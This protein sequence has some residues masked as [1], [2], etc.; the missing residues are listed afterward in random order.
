MPSSFLSNS[1]ILLFLFTNPSP[2]KDKSEKNFAMAFVRLMKEDGTV[3]QDGLQ[4]LVI[5]KVRKN[6]TV[7]SW[8]SAVSYSKKGKWNIK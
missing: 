6:K 8:T 2:A 7:N 3:L 4:D 5:F 1:L